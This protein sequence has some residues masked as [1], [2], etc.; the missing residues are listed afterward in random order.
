MN[1]DEVSNIARAEGDFWWYR[2]QRRILERFLDPLVRNRRLDRVLD[3]GCGTGFQAAELQSRY[4]C[5]AF[6]ADV[7]ELGLRYGRSRDIHRLCAGNLNELP[8]ADGTFDMV[9]TF[10]VL[11][12]FPR[13]SESQALAEMVRVLRPG[14]LLVI[15]A[16][17]FETLRS[18]HSNHVGER[19]RFT[20]SALQRTVSAAGVRLLRSTYA[21]T[22]L[23]PAA[24]LK[25]RVWERF[26]PGGPE[27]G[28]TPVSPLLNSILYSV[29]AAEAAL[30]AGNL[31]FP[32]GQSILIAAEKP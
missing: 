25:F 22:L 21:N 14:G 19:Q 30:I 11:V 9:T 8:F 24:F 5:R 32:V 29:L 31:N 23:L 27:S 13:N 10:D 15:R 26:T 28:V 7:E 16:A 2:G 4:R 20:R 1:P 18:R 6:G 3:A 12:H 17:A